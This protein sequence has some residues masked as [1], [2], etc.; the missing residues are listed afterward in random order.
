MGDALA[1]EPRRTAPKPPQFEGLRVLRIADFWA[2]G[3]GFRVTGFG[4]G[5][6]A[7]FTVLRVGVLEGSG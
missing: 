4:F 2:L 3:F 5:G 7:G 6:F 1:L